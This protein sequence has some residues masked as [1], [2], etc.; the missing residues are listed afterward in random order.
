MQMPLD[1]QRV[2]TEKL[3]SL[4]IIN[5]QEIL[6]ASWESLSQIMPSKAECFTGLIIF[7]R[8]GSK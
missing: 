8:Q 3:Y 1:G 6:G 5:N 4:A 2:F 7:I